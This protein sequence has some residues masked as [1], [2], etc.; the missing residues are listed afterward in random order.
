MRS[1]RPK[2]VIIAPAPPPITGQSI[3][4]LYLKEVICGPDVHFL[5]LLTR[6][7][8]GGWASLIAKIGRTLSVCLIL[9]RRSPTEGAVIVLDAGFGLLMNSLIIASLRLS[10]AR[11]FLSHHSFAYLNQKSW[12]M[13]FTCAIAGK[14][15]YHLMLCEDME[16]AFR[17]IYGVTQTMVLSN[18]RRVQG[19]LKHQPADRQKGFTIG[20]ISNL[21][22]EKGIGEFIELF[23]SMQTEIPDLRAIVAGPP[24]N[25]VVEKFMK[26]KLSC[27]TGRLVWLGPVQGE[28]KAAFFSQINLLVFPSRYKNE[29]QPNVVLES[30]Q[31]SVPVI[32]T[33]RGC[34]GSDLANGAGWALSEDSFLADAQIL[35][36]KLIRDYRVGA[37]ELHASAAASRF[38]T[39][40]EAAFITELELIRLVRNRSEF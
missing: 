4:S 20:Y 38:Y 6:P 14:D 30:L 16:D 24:A 18:A 19:E 36:R 7:L 27:N 29:A 13:S 40:R 34:I 22:F 32:S 26:E 9:L 1:A 21:S 2:T 35:L 39:M 25:T 10:S 28:Q 5:P 33:C 3:Y 31:A 11:L 12:L 8:T 23:E 15:A 37:W 17:K